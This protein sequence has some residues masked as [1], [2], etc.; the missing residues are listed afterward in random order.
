[1]T[2]T[3]P[4]HPHPRSVDE[5]FAMAVAMER[6]AARRYGELADAMERQG[7][8]ALVALFRRLQAEEQR[9]E[10]GIGDWARRH[11]GR[12]PEPGDFS[13]TTPE[14]TPAD[15]LAD[16]G[17]AQLLTPR[18][19]LDLAIHNEQ[20]A[21]A[22]FSRVAS[23]ARDAELRA[24]AEHMAKE[25]LNHV[26][27]LRLERRR[28]WRQSSDGDAQPTVLSSRAS[29][30]EQRVRLQSELADLLGPALEAMRRQGDARAPVLAA[31]MDDLG[32]STAGVDAQGMELPAV[33]RAALQ[34]LET[35]CESCL[36]TAER[37]PEEPLLLAAQAE[38][39]RLLPAVERLNE[40]LHDK[41]RA[42]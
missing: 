39:Q 17:G 32:I 5:L 18:R 41:T 15:E 12:S 11:R 4:E 1:M 16:A 34:K 7:R 19:A 33:L 30:N 29:L 27:L 35:A 9:H 10:T 37:A 38:V 8:P 14:C 26:A 25:E 20:R 3:A 22:F 24:Y 21:F 6:E 36:R 42:G 40:L 2:R 28:A 31:L 13:W 23:E